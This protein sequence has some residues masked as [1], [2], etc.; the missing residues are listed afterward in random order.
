MP[1]PAFGITGSSAALAI[2]AASTIVIGPL[3][4]KAELSTAMPI[5]GGEFG[6]LKQ[7]KI[8]SFKN[9]FFFFNP[10][11]TKNCKN[12]LFLTFLT[13]LSKITIFLKMKLPNF[14]FF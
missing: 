1:G 11:R 4:S 7:N 9:H 14:K 5:S 12:A 10:P 6:K 13:L 8:F 2:V 3:M